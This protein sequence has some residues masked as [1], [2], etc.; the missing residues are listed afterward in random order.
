MEE[1]DRLTEKNRTSVDI[2]GQQY[3]I[4]GTDTTSHI[5][6]VA[7]NV[8]QK[9]REINSMNPSLDTGKLAVLTAVNAVHDYL[10]LKEKYELLE[11]ELKIKE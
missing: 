6:L 7:S 11:N 3:T 10:K 8:E 9:M 4:V 1:A 5:R 2:Y